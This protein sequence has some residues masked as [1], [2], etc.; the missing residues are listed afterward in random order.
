MQ[1]VR[2]AGV[3]GPELPPFSALTVTV[4]GAPGLWE[5]AVKQFGRL[6]LEQVQMPHT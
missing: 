1:A 2:Q 6:S 3:S 4:P 5:D